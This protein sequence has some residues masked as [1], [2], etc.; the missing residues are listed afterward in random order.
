MFKFTELKQIHLEITNNC[1]A[2]C[3]MCNRNINGGMDNP[4]I[5][6]QNWTFDQFKTIM[7][8][9][10]LDQIDSYYFCGNFGDPILN[11]DLIKMCAWSKINA[12][13]VR[14]SIHTNGGARNTD[15]W[16]TLAHGLPSDHSVI[17]A[18][19]GLADTHHLYRVGTK[20]DTVINN[21]TAFIN[22]GGTAEWVF[23]KF[24]HNEHQVDDARALAAQLGFKKFTLKNS[25]RFILEPKVAV[26][27]SSGNTLYHIEP[28]SEVT[29]KFIDKKVIESYRTIVEQSVIACKS[30]ADKEVYI[31]AYGDLYPCCWLAS[32]PY[33]HIDHDAAFEVRTEML[34]QHRNMV[35]NLGNINTL[36]T[37]VKHIVESDKYQTAWHNYWTDD[38]LITCAR[39][40]GVNTV[41][42]KPRD[43]IVQ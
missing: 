25:S 38:K 34:I 10:V 9:E 27:N 8:Q 43:Q 2:G 21:A 12:P 11:N 35:A 18:L 7:H 20:F 1:Q 16:A 29:M 24:K 40:C 32:V 39:T 41:F 37:S 31:D 6:I 4:L 22:A 5:K 13:T 15:W 30:Q 26:K 17:F 14:V 19:D 42:A 23:I 3:P 33:S 36:A 28:P